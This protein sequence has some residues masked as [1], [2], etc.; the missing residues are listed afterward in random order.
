MTI[1]VTGQL[2]FHIAKALMQLNRVQLNI[3]LA[4]SPRPS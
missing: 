3:G 1:A 4:H 2:A